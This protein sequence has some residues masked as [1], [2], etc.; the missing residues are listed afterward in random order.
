MVDHAAGSDAE[1]ADRQRG[2][3]ELE[4]GRGLRPHLRGTIGAVY[5]HLGENPP[6][7]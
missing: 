2:I 3:R 4:S 1:R 7:A 6:I 5:H